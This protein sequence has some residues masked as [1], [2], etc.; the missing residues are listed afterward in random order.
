MPT[1]PAHRSEGISCAFIVLAHRIRRRSCGSSEGWRRLQSSWR[2]CPLSEARASVR[3]G[4]RRALSVA[5]ARSARTLALGIVRRERATSRGPRMSQA[6]DGSYVAVLTG[7]DYPLVAASH[8]HAFARQHQGKSFVASWKLPSP[9]FGSDGGLGRVRYWH[10]AIGRRRFHLPVPATATAGNHSRRRVCALPDLPRRGRIPVR[11]S[12]PPAGCAEVLPSHLDADRDAVRHFAAQRSLR[13]GRRD[14]REPVVHRLAAG[15]R[16]ASER[17]RPMRQRSWRA[18]G[19]ESDVAGKA[20]SKLLAR[21]FD[22][23]VDAKILDI[24]DEHATR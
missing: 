7:Q 22:T 23:E 17:A 2:G 18:A 8:I 10:Q 14:R 6:V 20:R 12:R 4:A 13:R 5:H 24:L 9:L 16:K 11:V 19:R 15:R 1:T 3:A 21:K